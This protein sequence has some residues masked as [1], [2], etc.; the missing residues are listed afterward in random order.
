[1][2]IFF[3]LLQPVH[4]TPHWVSLLSSFSDRDNAQPYGQPKVGPN[5]EREVILFLILSLLE[6]K[7][8]KIGAL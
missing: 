5:M 6:K 4:M 8:K 7:E 1:M 2:L 3:C